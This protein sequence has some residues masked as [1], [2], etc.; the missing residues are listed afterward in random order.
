MVYVIKFAAKI[1][2]VRYETR[3]LISRGWRMESAY[4]K[5]CSI[6]SPFEDTMGLYGGP[7]LVALSISCAVLIN[8][9]LW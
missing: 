9:R 8:G 4:Q 5:I 2:S 6:G 3:Y 1:I 7:I